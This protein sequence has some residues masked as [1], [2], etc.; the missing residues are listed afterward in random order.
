MDS[1]FSFLVGEGLPYVVVVAVIVVS[2]LFNR[3][4][5][6]K[7]YED[8]VLGVFNEV[9][10][11]ARGS[12]SG[13]VQKTAEFLDL[14]ITKYADRTGVKPPANLLAEALKHVEKLVFV[15]NKDS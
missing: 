5:A 7:K 6:I 12:K 4:P 3:S 2:W 11:K 13:K 10:K 9:E 14:F 15:K 8:L 1:V